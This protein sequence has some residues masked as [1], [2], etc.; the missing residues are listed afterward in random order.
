MYL[1]LLFLHRLHKI[2]FKVKTHENT[3]GGNEDINGQD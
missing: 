3:E 2:L 1:Y